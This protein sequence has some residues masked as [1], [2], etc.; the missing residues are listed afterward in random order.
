M[1][2]QAQTLIQRLNQE[3]NAGNFQ[4]AEQTLQELEMMRHD[5]TQAQQR[6]IDQLRQRLREQPPD[7]PQ[8]APPGTD[9]Y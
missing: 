3:I 5:L 9:P 8:P 1:Q 6:E 7:M 4:A 2:A